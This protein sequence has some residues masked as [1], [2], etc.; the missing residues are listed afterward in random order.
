MLMMKITTYIGSEKTSYRKAFTQQEISRLTGMYME[1]FIQD[2]I[3]T[4]S[5]KFKEY[6]DKEQ[7]NG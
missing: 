1:S 7:L 5:K 4:V 3:H 2:I 6:F